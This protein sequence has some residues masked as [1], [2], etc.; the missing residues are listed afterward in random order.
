MAT[1]LEK[2]GRSMGFEERVRERKKMMARKEVVD[3]LSAA[4]S[5]E[6]RAFQ[7]LRVEVGDAGGAAGGGTGGGTGGGPA[8]GRRRSLHCVINSNIYV[9]H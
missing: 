4:L 8:D 3:A 9:G 6:K 5:E 1:A 2:R 7:E